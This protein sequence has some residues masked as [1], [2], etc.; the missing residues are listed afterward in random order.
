MQLAASDAPLSFEMH[1]AASD[2]LEAPGPPF[3]FG[4]LSLCLDVE[5]P[6]E[7]G[8][9]TTLPKQNEFPARAIGCGGNCPFIDDPRRKFLDV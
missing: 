1:L 3:T 9:V 2:A 5:L 8:K 6:H 7:L 4:K